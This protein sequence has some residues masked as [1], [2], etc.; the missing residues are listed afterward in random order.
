[1]SAAPFSGAARTS[2][3]CGSG[4]GIAAEVPGFIGFAVG[5]TVFCGSAGRLA[6]QRA[7]RHASKPSPR[8]PSAIASSS[9]CFER[10]TTRSPSELSDRTRSG[11]RSSKEAWHMQLGMIGLGRM[12]A[13]MVR[14]LVKGG[15]QCVVFD[16]SPKAVAD[17]ARD[18]AVGASST[19]DLVRQSSEKPRA[20]WLMVP[21]GVV[22]KTIADLAPHLESGD[23]LDRRRQLVLRRRHPPGAS[24]RA[25]KVSITWM[26]E[27]AAASG[28]WS[29]GDRMMIGRTGGG[30]AA[31]RSRSSKTLAPG[32]RRHPAHPWTGRKSAARPSSATCTA[33]GTGRG[34]RRQDGR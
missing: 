30:G 9:T 16:V 6:E 3:K 1:M 4:S 2:A 24:A 10:A 32:T 29:A 12:G 27:P 31:P 18:K 8:S 28:G 25:R 5:R 13:N 19:A 33:A 22:D 11:H 7:N 34:I 23:I 14:R 21:A 20:V 15:H 17:L 26:S